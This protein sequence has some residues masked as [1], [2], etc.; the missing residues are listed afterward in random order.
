[1]QELEQLERI[2]YNIIFIILIL[3]NC[4]KNHYIIITLYKTYSYS[5]S[6]FTKVSEIIIKDI[7]KFI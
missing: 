7:I 2:I 5:F 4:V 1:M 3:N 6:L